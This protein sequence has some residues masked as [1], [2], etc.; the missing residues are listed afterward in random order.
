M[1]RTT[2]FDKKHYPATNQTHYCWQKYNEYV[3]CL[4]KSSGDEDHCKTAKQLALSI[5]PDE[6]V[7][8]W[9]EQREKGIF[10]GVQENAVAAE[11]KVTHH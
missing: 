7:Q 4:K 3:L 9:Q 6:W 1:L 10:L 2:P 5:C 11:A 8:T